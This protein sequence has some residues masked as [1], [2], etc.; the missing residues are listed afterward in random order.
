MK[1]QGGTILLL[2]LLLALTKVSGG[3]LKER[4]SNNNVFNLFKK[5]GSV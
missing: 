2:G 4:Y 3:V 5:L 1:K